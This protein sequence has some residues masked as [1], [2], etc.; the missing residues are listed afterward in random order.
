MRI[1]SKVLTDIDIGCK[2]GG[3]AEHCHKHIRN[4]QVHYEIVGDITHPWRPNHDRNGEWIAHQTTDEHGQVPDDERDR[5]TRRMSI[6]E[7]RARHVHGEI[8]CQRGQEVKRS[9]RATAGVQ[10]WH[11]CSAKL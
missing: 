7:L 3:Q 11:D 10:I 4:G 2:C 9:R 8:V 1:R 5:H 6:Q